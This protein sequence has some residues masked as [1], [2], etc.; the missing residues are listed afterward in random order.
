MN[1]SYQFLVIYL[2]TIFSIS[3]LAQ[4]VK[5]DKPPEYGPAPYR[6]VAPILNYLD[7]SLNVYPQNIPYWTGTC[8]GAAKTDN[9]EVRGKYPEDGWFVFDVSGLPQGAIINSITFH[10]YVNATYDPF[11][12]LTPMGNINPITASASDIK[13]YIDTH[14]DQGIAYIFRQEFDFFPGWHDFPLEP[15]AFP[16]LVNAIPQGWFACGLSDNLNDPSWYLEFDGWNGNDPYLVIEYLTPTPHD[17]GTIA[18]NVPSVIGVGQVTPKATVFSQSTTNETFDVTMTITPG[19]YTSTKTV[20]NLPPTENYVVSFDTWNTSLGEYI[21]EVCT[22]LANDPN[23][24]NNCKSKNVS[25]QN[26][27]YAVGFNAYDP[28]FSLDYGPVNFLLQTPNNLSLLAPTISEDFIC[29]GTYDIGNQTWYGYMYGTDGYQLFYTIDPFTG[30]MVNIGDSGDEDEV[31]RGMAY[32]MVTDNLYLVG[33]DKL[34]TADKTTGEITLVGP[35]GLSMNYIGLACSGAGQLFGIDMT[36]DNLIAINK[37]TGAATPIGYLG[38]DVIYAQSIDYDHNNELLYWGAWNENAYSGQLY[39][40]N[41]N[42][43]STTF[44][45]NLGSGLGIEMDAMAIPSN[46]VP[47]ELISFS[48]EVEETNVTL[49][50]ITASESNNYGFEVQRAKSEGEFITIGFVEGNVTSTEMN[51]YTF[52]DDGLSEGVYN[53][54]LKQIDLDGTFDYSNSVLVESVAPDV[55]SLDQNYP[56]PFNPSTKIF[57]SLA[58]DSK[59]NLKVFDILGQEVSTIYNNEL[60]AGVHNVTFNAGDANSGVYFYRLEAMGVDGSNFVDVKKM[61]LTK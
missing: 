38:F 20:N 6:Y 9:S 55:F 45:G 22:Q 60:S 1:K 27:T 51:Y 34:Y 14:W 53:Y 8:T 44:I 32:D 13:N 10:G 49:N 29:A 19:G 2:I 46:T 23:P 18:V 42:N 40:V 58:V 30:T 31:I 24:T 57:F 41:P 61:V 43:A 36:T 26:V 47:V 33:G 3:I 5:T 16:D 11:W 48:A 28:N 7:D 50:W 54:R 21:V 12:S 17:V 25:V 35:S 56:N 59:V 15:H 39:I 52:S 37:S 4:E